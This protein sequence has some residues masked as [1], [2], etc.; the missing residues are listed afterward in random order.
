MT[1]QEHD[2]LEVIS[3]RRMLNVNHEAESNGEDEIRDHRY[4][5]AN[6]DE[7]KQ[8]IHCGCI[9]RR[10]GENHNVYDIG[11]DPDN[12]NEEGNVLVNKTIFAKKRLKH[13][14]KGLLTWK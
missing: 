9:H 10:P 2:P 11:H 7:A 13:R 3:N 6:S 14:K 1:Q 4:D 8:S 12:A 5:V